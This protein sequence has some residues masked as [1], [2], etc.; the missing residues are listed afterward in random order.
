MNRSQLGKVSVPDELRDILLEFTISYL[1]EQPSDVIEYGVE[2]FT[3]LKL[4]RRTTPEE[5]TTPED[6]IDDGKILT[7]LLGTVTLQDHY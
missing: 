7:L 4:N 3:K 5:P 2:F 6:D 1:L